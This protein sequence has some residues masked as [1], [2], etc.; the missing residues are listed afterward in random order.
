MKW[1]QVPEDEWL[2]LGFLADIYLCAQDTDSVFPLP[3][4][5][6]SLSF[7]LF[8]STSLPSSLW[9]HKAPYEVS[10]GLW[11]DVCAHSQVTLF[12]AELQSHLLWE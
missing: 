5:S 7:P 8:F 2:G 9:F 12:K 4:V 10:G 6:F 1:E 3:P 11:K